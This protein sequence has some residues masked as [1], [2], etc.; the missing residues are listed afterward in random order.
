MGYQQPLNEKE[1][2]RFIQEM[3]R[4]AKQ[5][6]KKPFGVNEDFNKS[7]FMFTKVNSLSV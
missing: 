2:L 3:N 1:R 7:K 4:I 6:Q 5:E